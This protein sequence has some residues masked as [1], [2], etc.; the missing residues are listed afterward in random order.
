MPSSTVFFCI[1][2]SFCAKIK[3]FSTHSAYGQ[4]EKLVGKYLDFG[5]KMEISMAY[6]ERIEITSFNNHQDFTLF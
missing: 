2:T 1:F 3:A 6:G 4:Y 5:D